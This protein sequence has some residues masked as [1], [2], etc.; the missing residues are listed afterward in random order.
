MT[1]TKAKDKEMN[2]DFNY[3]VDHIIDRKAE[4]SIERWVLVWRKK[5][6]AGRDYLVP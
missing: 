2:C 6:T 3:S 4:I 5:D 1:I